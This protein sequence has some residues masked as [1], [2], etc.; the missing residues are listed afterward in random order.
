MSGIIGGSGA[1][2][3]LMLVAVVLAAV[4]CADT[5]AVFSDSRASASDGGT[6]SGPDALVPPAPDATAPGQNALVY[7]HSADELYQIDPDSLEVT[8]VGPFGWPGEAD[9][10]TDIALDKVGRMIGISYD[11]VY[12]VNKKTA[13]CAYLAPLTQGFN[14]LS[15]ITPQIAEGNEL[16]VATSDQGDV[17]E[18]DPETGRATVL[19]AFGGG[20]RSSGDLVSVRGFGTVATVT[21]L[22][23]LTDLLARVDPTTGTATVIGDTGYAEIWGLGFW[24]DKVYGF[25]EDSRFLLIDPQTGEATEVSKGG[26]PWWGAGVTTSAPVIK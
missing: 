25:T 12:E 14:G 24:K 7:A 6:G 20:L 15:F 26:G 9:T 4:G 13:V 2:R 11:K 1:L 22:S 19:G 3:R 23:S 17:F 16:L 8:L 21:R 18:I 5:N 10:M